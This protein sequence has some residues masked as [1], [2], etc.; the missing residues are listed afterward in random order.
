MRPKEETAL[1]RYCVLLYKEYQATKEHDRTPELQ[2]HYDQIV[3]DLHI[4]AYEVGDVIQ[5]SFVLPKEVVGD[6]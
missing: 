1:Y 4:D 3:K 2:Q 6:G 5:V